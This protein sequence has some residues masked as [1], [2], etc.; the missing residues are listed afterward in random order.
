LFQRGHVNARWL[1]PVGA[2]YGVFAVL[3]WIMG[4]R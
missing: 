3:I 2:I 4:V 1:V